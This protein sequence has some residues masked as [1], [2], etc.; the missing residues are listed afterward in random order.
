MVSLA[1]NPALAVTGSH[2]Q[3]ESE[4]FVSSSIAPHANLQESVNAFGGSGESTMS[5]PWMAQPGDLWVYRLS[6]S[7]RYSDLAVPPLN[8]GLIWMLGFRWR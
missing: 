5:L 2:P 3:G 8:R 1:A 6:H 4:R 7:I